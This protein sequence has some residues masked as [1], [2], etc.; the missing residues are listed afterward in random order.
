MRSINSTKLNRA[1]ILE[2]IS[3]ESIFAAYFN[4]SVETIQYCI[5]TGDLICSP[6]REDNH[7]TC[8]FRYD[9]RGRLKMK[10]FSGVWWGDCFDAVATVLTVI[11]DRQFDVSKKKDFIDILR[12]ITFTFKNIWYGKEVDPVISASISKAINIIKHSKPIIEVVVREWNE[13]DIN[14]W[15]QYGIN[16]NLLNINFIYPVD[17]YYINRKANPQPK[18]F[19]DSKDPCYCYNLG[20][21][22]NGVNNI[23]LYFPS[24]AKG[25]TRF[26]TNCNHLEGIYNLTK[27]DYDI[28]IITKST[29]DRLAISSSI[30]K[31]RAISGFLSDLNIG[32][33]NIP[34]ETYKLRH[35][36]FNWLKSKL[37]SESCIIS[38]MDNDDT[39][40]NEADFLKM[41]YNIPPVFIPKRFKSK[42]F[43]DFI[44]N[45]DETNIN[46]TIKT[47]IEYYGK[48]KRSQLSRQQ[49]TDNV[50]PF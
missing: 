47:F 18:Y 23:K 44:H 48:S 43:A 7:P 24:R 3:Q 1:A 37:K 38:L 25:N 50:I 31:L 41:F 2:K 30:L 32:V 36:E 15:K 35:I 27:D 9:S 13:K 28:I 11:Y 26:I 42:D 4:I 40:Y 6:I 21:D 12:H 10:D 39:G 46:K 19:Y 29:K 8:G 34:H 16:L 22:R 20:I 14:Y 33:I 45:T 49:Q 5:D 17:Q